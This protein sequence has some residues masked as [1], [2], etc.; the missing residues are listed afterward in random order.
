MENTNFLKKIYPWINKYKYAA[1]V[2]LVGI[3]LMLLPN[4]QTRDIKQPDAAIQ[5]T[6]ERT[7]EEQL[8]AILANV[9]GAGTV[10]VMLTTKEGEETI[11]QTNDDTSA[12]SD[13]ESI[14]SDTVILSDSNRV[15]TGLVRQ[16]Y[17]PVYQGAIILCQGAADPTVRLAIMDA[18]SKITGLSSDKISI[19]EMK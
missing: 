19:L 8:T 15:Q 3:G 18:V 5:A 13:T 4:G 2:L 17:G 11:Y 9:R 6:Q 10:Q 7:V 14:R 12:T 1:V 16:K